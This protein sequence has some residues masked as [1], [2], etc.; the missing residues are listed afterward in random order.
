MV[1][2][3]GDDSIAETIAAGDLFNGEIEIADDTD[4]IAVTLLAGQSY[5]IALSSPGATGVGDAFLSICDADSVLVGAD[6]DAGAG[7]DSLATYTPAETG[8]FYIEAPALNGGTGTDRIEVQ[9]A[10]HPD[11]LDSIDWGSQMSTNTVRVYFAP[12][13]EVADGHASRGWSACEILQPCWPRN[14]LPL[15]A[16]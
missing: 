4:W 7:L 1:A 11:F 10:P 3:P 8:T 13:G 14:R 6:D 5:S 12:P 9:E 15:S 2:I 16:T